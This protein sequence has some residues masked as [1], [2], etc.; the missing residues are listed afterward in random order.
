[1]KDCLSWF[2]IPPPMRLG[3]VGLAWLEHDFCFN[4][5]TTLFPFAS[6]FVLFVLYGT[7]WFSGSIVYTEEHTAFLFQ[8]TVAFD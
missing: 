1:M 4:D 6:F 3:W 5:C 8:H 2:W 7:G